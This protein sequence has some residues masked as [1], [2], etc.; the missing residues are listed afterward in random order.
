[1]GKLV[2]LM[3]R[4]FGKLTVIERMGSRYNHALWK[5]KC[6]CGREIVTY[7]LSLSQGATRACGCTKREWA[8]INGRKATKHGHYRVE[9]GVEKPS[10]T[11]NS[12]T[13]MKNRC[14]QKKHHNYLYYGGRGIK[15]C[16][17]WNDFRNFLRD[18]GERPEDCTLDRINPNGNYEPSNC[19]WANAKVQASTRRKEIHIKNLLY[20]TNEGFSIDIS[21]QNNVFI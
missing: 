8:I 17:E 12:W 10:K 3:G 9:N 1:M 14:N 15:I 4:K 5:C 19:R 20:N 2:D 13:S 11:Y 16:E 18:M 6:E 7:G 21:K